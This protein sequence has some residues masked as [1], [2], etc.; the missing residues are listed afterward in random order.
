MKKRGVCSYSKYSRCRNNQ[1]HT[2]HP[3]SDGKHYQCILEKVEI[4]EGEEIIM[5]RDRTAI[6]THLPHYSGLESLTVN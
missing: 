2:Q 1:S 3:Y 5:A 4:C 6:K